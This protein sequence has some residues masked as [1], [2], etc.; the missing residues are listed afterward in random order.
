MS[1]RLVDVGWHEV[2]ADALKSDHARL[3]IVCPFIKKRAAERLL[4]HGRP[5]Q[6]QVITRFNLRDFADGVSDIGALRFLLENGAR[7][8][9]VRNLHAKLYV[10]GES[11]V[12]LTSANLTEAALLRNHEFGFVAEDV[13]IVDQ[14]RQ[15]FDALWDRAGQDLDATRLADW[16]REVE[17]LLVMGIPPTTAVGLRDEGVDAGL[18]PGP[19]VPS[20]WAGAEGQAFVKF[21]GDSQNRADRSLEV[22][23]EVVTSGSHWACTY[24][25]A[26]RPRKVQEGALMFMG[27]L[28]ED[29]ADILIYGRAVGV[30]HQPGRDDAT[31]EDIGVRKWKEKYPHY[32]R[33]HHAEFVAGSLANGVS[34]NE[35]MNVLDADAFASSQRHARGG[36][37]STSPRRAYMR[38]AAVELSPQGLQWMLEKLE[39]AFELH[40][41]LAPATLQQLDWPV[42][43]A[44]PITDSQ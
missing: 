40:G 3:R 1:F 21:F 18:S 14:C 41:R 27:R 28:V 4:K 32:V 34:L 22:L 42:V 11:R 30:R 33:V 24:P 31:A 15:Y 7:I 13:G 44:N 23:K 10:F 26:K 39:H 25:Y 29:P 37:G 36:T 16:D 20:T 8:R 5:Q 2:L 35:M 17:K 38:Q 43:L 12:I 9:G 19:A 6:F